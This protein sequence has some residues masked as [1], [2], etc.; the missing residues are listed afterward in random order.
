MRLLCHPFVTLAIVLS[1]ISSVNAWGELGHRVTAQLADNLMS[2]DARYMTEYLLDDTMAD[3]SMWA[4]QI[5]SNATYNWTSTY[6]TATIAESA[7]SFIQ[8]RDCPAQNCVPNAVSN[9]SARLGNEDISLDEKTF[10]LKMI[11]H[12]F[13]DIH[14][15]MNIAY[16]SDN[17]GLDDKGQW[18]NS[19]TNLQQIH[20]QSIIER[21]MNELY[22]SNI[23]QFVD[24]LMQQFN[25]T[26]IAEW[27]T[28]SNNTALVCPVEWASESA[29]VVWSSVYTDDGVKIN[30]S[31]NFTLSDRYYDMHRDV[32]DLRLIIGGVR[33]MHVLNIVGSK[34]RPP[35][36]KQDNFSVI[37]V[38]ALCAGT[39]FAAAMGLLLWWWRHK[40]LGGYNSLFKSNEN[41]EPSYSAT[42]NGDY[43][44][45]VDA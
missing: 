42:T 22:N 33:L 1:C 37:L 7:C 38:S 14:Q 43:T 19:Y 40:H 5:K 21:V 2:D 10:A 44:R 4:D 39:A 20:Q 24:G 29:N 11:I 35:R 9:Y 26:Q 45:M 18:F 27:T 36:V 28:C 23:T 41:E 31:T 15:P 17:H 32:L 30:K 12:L 16:A 8:D 25:E 13:G 6:H 34:W 3:V